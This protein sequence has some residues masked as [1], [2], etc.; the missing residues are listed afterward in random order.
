LNLPEAYLAT[1]SACE[2]GVTKL[3]KT[4]EFIGLT[5]GLLHAGAASVICSLWTVDDISTSILM[6]KMYQNI[7]TGKGKAE[8]LRDAQLW[9]KDPN[10]R[11]EHI[12]MLP[13]LRGK[14][15]MIPADLAKPYYWA[16][17]VCSGV[18]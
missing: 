7:K 12:N 16:G 17:F 6:K 3:G 1:L 18:E 8:S 10:N 4:D 15:H 2:T 13:E 14:E 11:Q 5:S 9:L